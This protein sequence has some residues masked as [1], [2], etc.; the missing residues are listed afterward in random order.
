MG[1]L[2]VKQVKYAAPGTH[3]DGDG[4]L[5][6]VRA[7]GSRSWILRV[8]VDGQRRDVGLG[9]EKDL[10]LAEA[11]EKAAYLRKLARQGRDPIAERDKHRSRAP[12]FAIAL[13]EAHRQLA[14]GWEPKTG[15][16]FLSSLSAHALPV[17]GRKRVDAIG[18]ADLIAV[19][20]PIWTDKPDQAKKVRRRVVQ[21]LAFA[22]ARGWRSDPVPDAAEIRRGLA[23]QPKSRGFRAMPYTK[24]PAFVASE[25]A[26]IR[27]PA[28][29]A[30]LFAILTAARSQEVRLIRW[31]QI[32]RAGRLW[33]R[34]AQIMKSR[35]AHTS[36]LNPAALAILDMAG[37][38]WGQAEFVFPSARDGRPLSDMSLSK[39]MRSAGEE[40]TVHGFRSSFRDWAAEL[41]P[42][43]PG[44]VAEMALAHKVGDRVV[45]A[46]LRTDLRALRFELVDAWGAFVAPELGARGD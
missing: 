39:M 10:S 24:V 34:P 1:K 35:E 43:I 18:A 33:A 27:T 28:R 32:D 17:I 13:V 12:T 16:A 22:K 14:R 44:D 11:R 37:E 20:E 31:E 15:E 8:Q 46:Y 30:L 5:L 36:T 4:L 6:K 40:A 7:S 2:T 19:L 9:S 41:M 25:L 21:V 3:V 26:K 29:L 23:R 42:Q 45:Q 38:A